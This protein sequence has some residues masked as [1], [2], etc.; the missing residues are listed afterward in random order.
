[1]YNNRLYYYKHSDYVLF[2]MT[3]GMKESG[4]GNRIWDLKERGTE[5]SR[6]VA[7][8]NVGR[9]VPYAC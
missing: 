8:A 2:M 5:A 7:R 3:G 6:L 9:L 4:R 1:M